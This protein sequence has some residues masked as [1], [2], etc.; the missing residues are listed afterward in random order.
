M[1]TADNAIQIIAILI[2]VLTVAIGGLTAFLFS[3]A[4]KVNRL[5]TREETKT[6]DISKIEKR[7]EKFEGTMQGLTEFLMMRSRRPK[8]QADSNHDSDEADTGKGGTP[9]W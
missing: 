7:Q 6:K 8:Q 3:L 2:G 5:E 9:P 1:L 4:I